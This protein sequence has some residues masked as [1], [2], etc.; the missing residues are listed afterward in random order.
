MIL[1]DNTPYDYLTKIF[2]NF[3]KIGYLDVDI[4]SRFA[5]I[6]LVCYI[7]NKIQEKVPN[8]T[9]YTVLQTLVKGKKY[10]DD[11]IKGIAC[12]CD[13]FGYN[14]HEFPTFNLSNK[15]IIKKIL[16]ILDS[17]IPF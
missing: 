16:E 10:P 6:S 12:I 4:T 14:C 15:E 11:I 8:A 7:T 17:Y 9:N 5:L 2:D 3:F 1:T 13:G